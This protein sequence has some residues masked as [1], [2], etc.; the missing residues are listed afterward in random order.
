MDPV[1]IMTQQLTG[2][3]R[4]A[5]ALL[6]QLL[7]AIIIIGLT[8]LVSHGLRAILKRVL[9]RTRLR[10]S[11]QNLVELL[12][13]L[14]IWVLG[15]M[16]AAIIV[17][18]NLTPTKVLAG[19]GIGSVAIGF[20]FKDVF[21]NFLAGIIILMR[22]KM[23]IGDYIECNGLEGQV[24]DILVRETYIR[25]TDGQLVITPNSMLF[26]NPLTIRTDLDHRRQTVICGIAY[27]EDV[28]TSRDVIKRA[29][30]TATVSI[31]GCTECRCLRRNLQI[32]PSI[33]K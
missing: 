17:F 12:I 25:Q 29:V 3:T 33:L 5:I 7:L 10:R 22:R 32:L 26:K 9:R 6:P 8:Y 14:G 13:N 18:P 11:L 16:I 2:I 24:E 19:L 20:A 4:E 31:P 27:G 28:D 23:R 1:N 21:E 15:F 30:E